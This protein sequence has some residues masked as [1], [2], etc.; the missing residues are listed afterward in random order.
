MIMKI[1]APNVDEVNKQLRILHSNKL[2]FYSSLCTV[3]LRW[4][5]RVARMGRHERY[6]KCGRGKP[7]GKEP[8]QFSGIALGYE[9]DNRGFESGQWL[10][11]F[12]FT[13]ASRPALGPIQSPIQWLPGALSLGIKWQE[14]ET[15]HSPPPSAKV[16]N[17]WNYTSI[18]AIRLHGVVLGAKGRLSLYF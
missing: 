13:A 6:T 12:L 14:R 4:A 8:R 11:M 17:P 2:H 18:R 5:V 1:F 7:L 10:W 15:D 9:L 16:K 3:R